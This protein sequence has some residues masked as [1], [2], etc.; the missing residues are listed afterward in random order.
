MFNIN[1]ILIAWRDSEVRNS[2]LVRKV[3]LGNLHARRRVGGE[4]YGYANIGQQQ[5]FRANI[6]SNCSIATAT[7]TRKRI[8]Q[9]CG[10][11]IV[12]CYER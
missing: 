7:A 2:D 3:S 12:A 6:S 4:S 5:L 10:D 9:Q 11:R 1:V 8:L